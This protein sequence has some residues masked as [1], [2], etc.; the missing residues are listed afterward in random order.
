V[1]RETRE[2]VTREILEFR[3]VR[4]TLVKQVLLVIKETLVFKEIL[5]P[6]SKGIREFRVIKAIL[7]N[8]EIPV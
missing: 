7:E 6:V 3:A 4:A 2:L 8:R 1:T 5:E